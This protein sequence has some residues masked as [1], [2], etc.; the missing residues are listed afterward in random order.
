M[1]VV[2]KICLLYSV[3]K[4]EACIQHYYSVAIIEDAG[5]GLK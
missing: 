1:A 3:R 5:F 2:N 4:N